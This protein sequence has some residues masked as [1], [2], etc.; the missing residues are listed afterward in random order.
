MRIRAAD[1]EKQR[2]R[3][4]AV[5]GLDALGKLWLRR[6]IFAAEEYDYTSE[7]HNSNVNRTHA[8]L[9]HVRASFGQSVCDG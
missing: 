9:H 3:N 1:R 4:P 5:H 7:N 6:P 8:R 2:A